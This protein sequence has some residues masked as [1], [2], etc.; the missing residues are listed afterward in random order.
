MKTVFT[1]RYGLYEYLVMSFRLT[2]AP[3][4]FMYLMNSV[5][6]PE[7]DQFVVVFIDYILVYSKSSKEHEDHLQIVLQRLR[8]HQLY[9]KFSKC[10]FWI[11]EV[12]FL[13]QVVSPEGIVV[14]PS[15]VI[16]VLEW[17]PPT[18]MSEVRSFLGFAGY[19]RRFILNFS[20][21]AKPITELLKRGNKY[22][23][24]EAC[25]EAFKHLKK[26]LT[27]SPVLPQ[28]DTAKPFD[29]Y[30]DA[31]GTGL[32]GVLMQEGHVISYSSRQLRR[33]EEHYPTHDL[34]L[35]AVV[36]ALR[37]WRHYLLRNVVHIY[38]DQK[39]LKYIFTQPGLN[40]RQQRWLELIKDYEL[41]V[42]YH[43]VKANV[44]AD[45]LSHKAHS[46]CLAAI[47]WTRK[48]SST[49]EL[50][51][52]S[53]F[54]ITLMP[55][56]KAEIVAAQKDDEGMGHIRRRMQEGDPKVACFREDAEGT[57]WFKERLVVPRGEALKKKILDEAHTSNYSIH[58]GSTKMYH[59]LRQQFWWTRMKREVARYV[60]ECDTC[61][62]VKADYMKPGG[63][64]QLLSI[65]EWK[66]YDISM[67][68]IVGLPMTTRK[69]DLIWVIV[70]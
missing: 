9:A 55:T 50:P 67:D 45:A 12:P 69:F 16:E 42:H 35:V 61:R 65:P 21:I 28:P 3:A 63:L 46:N 8:E 10:E 30:C 37:T 15:K 70:D 39:S 11:K 54:N 14:D 40:M 66:W 41:E 5:F 4:H 19:Y 18:T 22:V 62:K 36:M 24:S 13:G 27:T 2:N 32:G 34:E 25:D 38:M 53:L 17:K 60:S 1:M 44:V 20:K 58:P 6:M 23:W 7:L 49:Q 52:L 47:H 26:L 33:L 31:F 68:F 51:N 64:L 59:D 56:L 48:E 43:R 57:L 29:V